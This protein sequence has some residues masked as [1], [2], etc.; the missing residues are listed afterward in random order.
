MM[1]LLKLFL[2]HLV[3]DFILQ[4]ESW[5]TD[6]AIKKHRSA[7]LYIHALLHGLLTWLLV[8]DLSFWL[9]ALAISATH[10][11]IDL[12]KV[13]FQKTNNKMT[14]FVVDQVLHI[15]V[16]LVVWY[17]WQKPVLQPEFIPVQS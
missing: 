14:W 5:V 8:W 2:A 13:I 12:A 4:P 17:I 3:G 15:M 6:K 7:R 1:L 11:L 10:L 9:A 16:L